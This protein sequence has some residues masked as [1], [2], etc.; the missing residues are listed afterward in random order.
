MAIL[1]KFWCTKTAAGDIMGT[2]RQLL[3]KHSTNRPKKNARARRRRDK[4]QKK[5]LV[6]TGI[7]ET[8]VH[9]MTSKDVRLGL[10]KAA[11]RSA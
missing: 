9:R 4:D 1:R 11:R 6:A 10:R 3:K 2:A 5:R 7:S 8:V